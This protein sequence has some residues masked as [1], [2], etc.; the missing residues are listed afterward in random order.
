MIF[1]TKLSF[2]L[3]IGMEPIFIAFG[4]DEI[5]NL[6]NKRLF[7]PKNIFILFEFRTS[8]TEIREAIIR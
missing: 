2:Q 7:H 1:P 3:I 5:P 4:T 8:R 6:V